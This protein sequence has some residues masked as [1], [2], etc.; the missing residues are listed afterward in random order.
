MM[1]RNGEQHFQGRG[2]A[3]GFSNFNNY[4]LPVFAQCGQRLRKRL[5][6]R[7]LVKSHEGT[8][9]RNP[10]IELPSIVAVTFVVAVIDSVA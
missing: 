7:N 10:S 4:R 6:P 3:Y 2:N 8:P 1:Y 9:E 5:C